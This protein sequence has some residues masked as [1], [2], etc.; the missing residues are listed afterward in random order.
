MYN[1]KQTIKRQGTNL[2]KIGKTASFPLFILLAFT[3]PANAFDL[4]LTAP[5]GSEW[6]VF[7]TSVA[8][9]DKTA[10]IGSRGDYE[11]GDASVSAYLFDT[12]TGNLLHQFTAPDGSER[13]YF[14]ESVALTDKTALIGSRGDD[15]NGDAS[16]SAYLFDT[17]TGNLLHKLTAP[18]GSA[19]D[20]FGSSV[21]IGENTALIAA[22]GDD[23]NGDA[24]GSAY[25]FDTTTGNLLHK[26]TPPD[27]SRWD[28]FGRSVA[29][30]GNTA[31]IG[32]YNLSRRGS[33]Y[34]FDTTTGN[35]LHKFTPP[36]GYGLDFFGWSVALSDHT[37][38][39]GSHNH[40]ASGSAYLFETTTG[41]LLQKLTPPEGSFGDGFGYSVALSNKTAVIGT[42]FEGDSRISA[43]GSAY[44]FDTTTGNLL[45]KF[46]GDGYIWERFG[47]SVDIRDNTALIGSFRYEDR[48]RDSGSAYLFTINTKSSNT[49][50]TPEPSSLLGIVG[51]VA[52]AALSL[53]KQKQ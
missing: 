27:G 6:D 31:L 35:L 19:Y 53:K 10:L 16:G 28:N 51:T 43:M 3:A 49:K 38:L 36:D 21:A 34:L 37:A 2:K 41:N 20:N 39:I 17:I 33:A 1:Q 23:N 25:L 50:S 12:T 13:D 22:T 18:D 26:F 4:K 47:Y 40:Y 48:E 32:S 11:N 15:D 44:L 42:P 8:L 46:T 45:Q 7:G 14:G 29:L 30:S 5:D 24:R 52:I 9:T